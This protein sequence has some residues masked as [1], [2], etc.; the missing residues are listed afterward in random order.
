M[1]S[2]LRAVTRTPIRN[3]RALLLEAGIQTF[4][5]AG[6]NGCS[7]QDITEAAGVPKGSFYNYFDS[8]EALAAEAVAHYWAD[9]AGRALD[10][11]DDP[12]RPPSARLRRYF[13]IAAAEMGQQ[14][15]TCGCL[16]GSM[17]AERS[18]HSPLIAAQ[19]SAIFDE[20]SRRIGKCLREAQDAGEIQSG[21]DP[22]LLATFILNAWEGALQRAR[23]ERGERPLRQFIEMLF[24]IF[25]CRSPSFDGACLPSQS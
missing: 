21:S 5:K 11:L 18:D 23:I 15:F 8:K 24:T 12:T 25:A 10:L 22:E 17:A 2:H 20:W 13:E 4:S 19:L 3:T 9:A 6:F 7:V 16:L 1:T 14:S